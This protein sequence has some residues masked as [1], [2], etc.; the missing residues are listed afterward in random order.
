MAKSSGE[1][2]QVSYTVATLDARGEF[3]RLRTLAG[4]MTPEARD[5]IDRLVDVL[6]DA[7]QRVD[8]MVDDESYCSRVEGLQSD[9]KDAEKQVAEE[10]EKRQAAESRL[11]ELLQAAEETPEAVQSRLT[12]AIAKQADHDAELARMKARMDRAEE[13]CKRERDDASVARTQL[14]AAQYRMASWYTNKKAVETADHYRI[15]YE[16]AMAQFNGLRD[17][18]RKSIQLAY[19]DAARSKVK[20]EAIRSVETGVESLLRLR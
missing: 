9:L 3:R 6:T 4:A 7:Y 11:E 13:Q 19:A 20:R 5:E 2:V 18:M 16:E 10:E 14:A 8:G 12:V 1:A 17:A 15:K